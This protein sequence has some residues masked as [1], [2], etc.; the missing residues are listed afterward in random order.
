[1]IVCKP[2]EAEHY[3]KEVWKCRSSPAYFL[4]SYGH[5][6]DATQGAWIPFHLWPA[7]LQALETEQPVQRQTRGFPEQ[8][9]QSQIDGRD[10]AKFRR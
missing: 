5:L 6:Y 9:M 1:M 8:I 2:S 10:R 7:Q 3:R 4:D